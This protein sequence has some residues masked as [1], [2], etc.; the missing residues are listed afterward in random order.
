MPSPY[1]G[2][3]ANYPTSVQVPI[4]SDPP[5]STL[6]A[7][8]WNGTLDRTAYTQQHGTLSNLVTLQPTFSI[9][10]GLSPSTPNGP[11]AACFNDTNLTIDGTN[12]Q[13][14]LLVTWDG[15][16]HARVYAGW[17]DQPIGTVTPVPQ[18]GGDITYTKNP[19][20]IAADPSTG[21]I[22][23][24][25]FGG[26]SST[27]A[28]IFKMAVGGSFAS[29][30][31]VSGVTGVSDMQIVVMGGNLFYGVGS[32]TAGQAQV[33]GSFGGGT[34]GLTA[35]NWIVRTNG[36]MVL[37]VPAVAQATPT[38]Y[39]ATGTATY[40]SASI[41]LATTDIPMDL[42]WN[43]FVNGGQWVLTVLTTTPSTKVWTSPDGVTWT[44]AATLLHLPNPIRSIA[45]VGPHVIGVMANNTL[46]T[47]DQL[48]SSSDGGVTWT[49]YQTGTTG[50]VGS[51]SVVQH[52]VIAAP[53]Q[54]MC[55]PAVINLS[56]FTSQFRLSQIYGNTDQVMS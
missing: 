10:S 16:N 25:G 20:S 51:G 1:V 31:T 30:L 49:S 8:A 17:F 3:P 52:K 36:S 11:Y 35:A 21:A 56:S 47:P 7:T 45:S 33:N 54:I 18:I 53:N 39:K 41:G 5:S 22:Y 27:E 2:N 40:S 9:S 4:G 6:F 14:W 37:F 29:F 38:V 26:V 48:C 23:V 34:T 12:G 24:G 42:T 50:G 55:L 19:T 43:A 28:D 32:N 44:L 46:N 13:R 15:T